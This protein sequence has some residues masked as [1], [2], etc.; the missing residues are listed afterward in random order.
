MPTSPSF[1]AT[2]ATELAFSQPVDERLRKGAGIVGVGFLCAAVLLVVAVR[3]GLFGL[4]DALAWMAS[5]TALAFGAFLLSASL[6]GIQ[7]VVTID[8]A[9][10]TLDEQ[11]RTFGGFATHAVRRCDECGPLA[12]FR[13]D[14]AASASPRWHLLTTDADGSPVEIAECSDREEVDRLLGRIAALRFGHGIA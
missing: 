6:Y 11:F 7:H 1:E 9:T 2:Q 8:P 13:D 5:G 10:A 14:E 12:V 3:P 4:G